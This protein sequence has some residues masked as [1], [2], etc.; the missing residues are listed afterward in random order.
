MNYQK[1]QD[2]FLHFF[3]CIYLIVKGE[4]GKR[5]WLKAEGNAPEVEHWVR[6]FPYFKISINKAHED[7]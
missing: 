4:E 5:T 6:H 7:I 1:F 3:T 2:T